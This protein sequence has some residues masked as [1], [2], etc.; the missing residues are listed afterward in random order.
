MFPFTYWGKHRHGCSKGSHIIF[1]TP[2]FPACPPF[3]PHLSLLFSFTLFLYLHL[4]AI[5]WSQYVTCEMCDDFLKTPLL[6]T[7][8]LRIFWALH[9]Q[10]S[11][12]DTLLSTVK[13]D[14]YKGASVPLERTGTESRA[15][16]RAVWQEAGL[17]EWWP[18]SRRAEKQG[19]EKT[20]FYCFMLE[21]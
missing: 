10:W 13:T 16:L 7:G 9:Y 18:Q 8:H 5:P 15:V 14:W 3:H 21:T 4:V 17:N 2:F 6:I 20:A 12:F 19:G 1:I 11:L